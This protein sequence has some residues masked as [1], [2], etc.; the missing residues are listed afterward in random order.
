MV[1]V[2][3][4]AKRQISFSDFYKLCGWL[5][6]NG[7][8]LMSAKPSYVEAALEAGRALGFS[9]SEHSFREARES[10]NINW[11]SAMFDSRAGWRSAVMGLTATLSRQ[12]VAIEAATDLLLKRVAELESHLSALEKRNGELRAEISHLRGAVNELYRGTNVKPPAGYVLP[13][14]GSVNRNVVGNS[15]AAISSIK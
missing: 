4:D 6:T 5:Q 13:P 9:V 8:R 12:K 2:M 3:R 11:Q 7:E 15:V 1:S 14:N 10:T